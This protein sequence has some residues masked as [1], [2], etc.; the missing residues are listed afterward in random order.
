MRDLTTP[1]LACQL[2]RY[3]LLNSHAS[4]SAQAIARWWFDEKDGV[5]VQRLDAALRLLIDRGA[6]DERVAADGRR[7]YRRIGS[8]TLLHQLLAE[9]EGQV[10][11][12]R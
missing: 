8:D 3:S 11:G 10:H 4:D 5:D 9:L 7:R 6:F 12:G 1:A 2:L